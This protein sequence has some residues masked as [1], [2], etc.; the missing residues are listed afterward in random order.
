V[1]YLGSDAIYATNTNRK[2]C[3]QN[4]IITGFVRKG[5]AGKHEIN[6]KQIRK[7]IN[8]K[9][10]T[11][12]EGTF[13]KHKNHYNLRSINARISKTELLWIFFGIHTGNAVEIGKRIKQT[14]ETQ[15]RA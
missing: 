11:E 7:S 5:R 10:A 1:K 4:N 14:K 12:M 15:Q 13:G 9:R 6:L 3:K 8:I 2:Y